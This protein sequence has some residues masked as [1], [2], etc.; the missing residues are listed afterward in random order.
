LQDP[1]RTEVL[2]TECYVCVRD[3]DN[4]GRQDDLFHGMRG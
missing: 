3:C 1:L 4:L 2:S